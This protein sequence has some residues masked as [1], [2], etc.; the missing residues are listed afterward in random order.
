MKQQ[1]QKPAATPLSVGTIG[2]NQSRVAKGGFVK[3]MMLWEFKDQEAAHL[4][5]MAGS[6]T[7]QR[8]K[9]GDFSGRL[10]IDV[11]ER[12]SNLFGIHKA[13][14]ILFEQKVQRDGW[15]SKPNDVFNGSSAKDVLLN[16]RLTDLM[17]VRRYL[18]SVRGGM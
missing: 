16:G 11:I 1:S 14:G 17:R 5:G 18:D 10:G 3:L 8:W 9:A 4:L 2:D 15:V 12:I 6:R 13:L 7:Y